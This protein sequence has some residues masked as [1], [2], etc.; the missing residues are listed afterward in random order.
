MLKVGRV[1]SGLDFSFIYFF[2]IFINAFSNTWGNNKE[3]SWC[4]Q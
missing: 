3:T 4:L 2:F 1:F